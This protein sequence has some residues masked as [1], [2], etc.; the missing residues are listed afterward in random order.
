[1][2]SLSPI[3]IVGT[4]RCGTSML[5]K[6][7]NNFTSI[8]IPPESHFIPVFLKN[9]HKYEPLSNDENILRL[10]KDIKEF[11]YVRDWNKSFHFDIKKV[12]EQVKSRTF[13][14]VLEAI[15]SEFARQ[16]GKKRWGDKTPPYITC[17]SDLY[18]LF[19]TAKFL[20]IIRDGRDCA[21]SVIRCNWGPK[22]IYK[23]A[24]WWRES[25]LKGQQELEYLRKVVPN[26]EKVYLEVKYEDILDNP[27]IELK[28]IFDFLQEPFDVEIIDKLK[29]RQDNKFKWKKRLSEREK[30]LFEQ[31]AGDI[32][33][34]Y[35]YETNFE[36]LPR[37]SN[38]TKFYYSLDNRIKSLKNVYWDI[39]RAIYKTMQV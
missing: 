34:Y 9:L 4:G 36:G 13:Q 32:L 30:Q 2:S 26:I 39:K 7:I 16:K 17:M 25:L 5:L 31:V 8:A 6:I 28:R 20:H 18:S 3:F 29:I 35:G 14:G 15:Y 21:L 10:L 1:M 27:G 37:L 23:S 19:P 11:P 33:R 38:F 12:A 22:N 24:L